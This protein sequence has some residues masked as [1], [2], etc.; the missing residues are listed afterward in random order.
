M[1]LEWYIQEVFYPQDLTPGQH[2]VVHSVLFVGERSQIEHEGDA[3]VLAIS[4]DRTIVTLSIEGNIQSVPIVEVLE[5]HIDTVKNA[6]TFYTRLELE[7]E[8]Q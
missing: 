1:L 4:Q 5:G 8:N 2:L 6:A 3:T 7:G